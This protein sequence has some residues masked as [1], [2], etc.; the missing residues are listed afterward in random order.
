MVLA[1]SMS[2]LADAQYW[3][4]SG[5]TGTYTS[6]QNHGV[7]AGIQ[8][9]YQNISRGSLGFW[10]GED[11]SN[12]AF[13]QAGYEITN[14]SGYYPTT[15][16]ISGC[17]GSTFLSAGA[18]AWF[19]EYFPAGYNGNSFLGG[20]GA[21]GSVGDNGT[22][23]TYSFSSSGNVW[24]VYLNNQ[25]I[26]SVDLGTGSSGANPPSA[27]GEIADTDTNTQGL[28]L[29]GFRDLKF[30]DGTAYKYVPD[31]MSYSGYGK[32]S[33]EALPNTYGV[34]EVGSLINY[35]VVGSGLPTQADVKLWSLGYNLQLQSQWGNITSMNNYSAYS[36][37]QISAPQLVSS[38][39]G[40]RE[41]FAGW[42]GS[43]AGSYT[44]TQRN[45]SVVMNGDVMETA[46]WQKQYYIGALSPYDSVRGGG[47]YDA[48]STVSLSLNATV[49]G[50][51]YGKRV[52][53]SHWSGG[54]TSPTLQFTASA[55]QNVT[56]FWDTQYMVNAT[57]AYGNATGSGWYDA[58]STAHIRLSTAFVPT[59][60]GTA[61]GFSQWSNG[62][63]TANLSIHVRQPVFLNAIF[64][65]QYLVVP[66]AY[67]AYGNK[68]QGPAS[69]NISGQTVGSGGAYLFANRS[70]NLQYVYYKGAMVLTNHVF[71]PSGSGAM[72][73]STRV[74]NVT[75]L[76]KSLVGTP[77]NASVSLLFK[78][79]STYE[80][81]MGAEGMLNFAQVPYGE[82]NGTARYF[83]M[84]ERVSVS[85]GGYAYLSFLTPLVIGII[86]AGILAIIA[87]WR[88]SLEIHRR[89]GLA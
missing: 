61:L 11:L 51:G 53:F 27:L 32:G 1:S 80:G 68:L 44:G 12:G 58:N 64:G 48:N 23:N 24:T 82:V 65:Q 39:S 25:T 6:S 13:I 85:E 84:A 37:V 15:C 42:A 43:G 5:A 31:A 81:Y 49:I 33:L 74:Y 63:T 35:F 60:N 14:S 45:A 47:W 77:L 9:V 46:L 66:V 36:T 40:V 86:V 30:Y 89:R 83:G 73:F 55:P 57:T 59:S 26:G 22:Y 76:A 79:G 7:S 50:T 41:V 72:D 78:N 19:W 87:S 29:V 4:Q 17:V 10:I 56:L 54:S 3:F 20:I 71:I 34:K 69:Y 67:D 62:N 88:V 8:T 21:S 18:P 28:A 75:I 16:T 2:S 52:V 38:G 70:Y